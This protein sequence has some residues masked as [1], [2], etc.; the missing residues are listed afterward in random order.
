[1]TIGAEDLDSS[2]FNIQG[3][4]FAVGLAPPTIGCMDILADNHNIDTGGVYGIANGIVAFNTH[5]NPG[6]P[7]ECLY[8]GC[9]DQNSSSFFYTVY[10]GNTYYATLH[11]YNSFTAGVCDYEGCD[12]PLAYN[13]NT[14]CGGYVLPSSLSIT[15]TNNGC[16]NYPDS[17]SCDTVNGGCTTVAG[18]LGDFV[19]C[20]DYYDPLAPANT[21]AGCYLTPLLAQADACDPANGNCPSCGS[22]SVQG[23]TD[24]CAPNYD[25]LATCDDGSCD[26]V[27]YGCMDDGSMTSGQVNSDGNSIWPTTGCLGYPCAPYDSYDSNW[28]YIDLTGTQLNSNLG[29]DINALGVGGFN[30]L[31]THMDCRCEYH[32]C[33][34]TQAINYESF[35][36]YEDGSCIYAGCTDPASVNGVTTYNHPTPQGWS[37]PNQGTIAVTW[38]TNPIDAT[39]EDGSCVTFG[40]NDIQTPNVSPWNSAVIKETIILS[41]ELEEAIESWG[42]SAASAQMNGLY[43]GHAGS[44]DDSVNP[45]GYP[46]SHPTLGS[47]CG[48]PST[49][50]N[51]LN[52]QFDAGSNGF[53]GSCTV[54]EVL[55]YMTWA[56][57]SD[58]TFTFDGLVCTQGF[59]NAWGPFDSN[60]FGGETGHNDGFY[61]QTTAGD[62]GK[63]LTLPEYKTIYK[64]AGGHIL[65]L[66]G[67][68][69]CAL[70]PAFKRLVIHNQYITDFIH[71][72]SDTTSPYY[73]LDMLDTLF[74]HA[75]NFDFLSLKSCRLG[76]G[77]GHQV[78]DLSNWSNCGAIEIADNGYDEI[79]INHIDNPNCY[80]ISI[81]NN[82]EFTND[83]G[84]WDGN[85]NLHAA[86]GANGYSR[87]LPVD[88]N[89]HT[90]GTIPTINQAVSQD[91]DQSWKQAWGNGNAYDRADLPNQL[92][93]SM[94]SSTDDDDLDPSNLGRYPIGEHF[95]P[96]PAGFTGWD[97]VTGFSGTAASHFVPMKR[98]APIFKGGVL[99]HTR[100][101]YT[102]YLSDTRRGDIYGFPDE[103]N[104]Q[105]LGYGQSN[106]ISG[107][108]FHYQ[109][110]IIGE[111]VSAGGSY[112]NGFSWKSRPSSATYLS[113]ASNIHNSPIGDWITSTLSGW[114]PDVKIDM[115]LTNGKNMDNTALAYVLQSSLVLINLPNLKHVWLGPDWDPM[116]AMNKYGAYPGDPNPNVKANEKNGEHRGFTIKNCGNGGTVYVHTDGR[117]L[118]FKKRYGT[119][120]TAAEDPNLLHDLTNNPQSVYSTEGEAFFL[121][122]FDSNVVF[123]D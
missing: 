93:H 74:Q 2:A 111:D 49:F 79:N 109:G 113:N 84:T 70:N 54:S 19:V 36:N 1:M 86:G 41:S 38:Y 32:G 122:F 43:Y 85:T 9:M 22:S 95:P 103:F 50:G 59:A 40:C 42:E 3:V 114:D 12:D 112:Y 87:D 47:D 13:V 89:T 27:L 33:T 5:S 44:F 98:I 24:D 53:S 6:D 76:I 21:P 20:Y 39:V 99:I 4:G 64:P 11:Q 31:A 46:G 119:N 51:N 37:S 78:L 91:F 52:N 83:F 120:D 14:T 94:Y 107:Y 29:N 17:W 88:W 72:E 25:P 65:D 18:G 26:P 23:C 81:I 71:T 45:L 101:S 60:Q 80:S 121:Q 35:Y 118:E 68:Q 75:H 104:N 67:I 110:N 102:D 56:N 34:D 16:C 96:Q 28:S 115:Q 105:V 15:I 106:L 92:K 7:N 77:T 66:S 48:I 10:N 57:V 108:M 63:P 82:A 30:P 61:L 117:A 69:D 90:A 58:G 62:L 73:Q 8:S 55:S 123:V 97:V 100:V 116:Y